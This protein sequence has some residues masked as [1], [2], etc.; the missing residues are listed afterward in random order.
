MP[1]AAARPLAVL[2]LVRVRGVV[3]GDDVDGAVGQ[4]GAQRLDVGGGAQRRVDLVDRVVGRGQLVGEQQVVRGD[5]GGDV[6]AARLGPADDLDRAGRGD[7]ADVQPG[8]DVRGEQAR[9]GR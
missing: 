3:G 4:A 6:P 2:V 8:A 5:L 7:V 1:K 9:R